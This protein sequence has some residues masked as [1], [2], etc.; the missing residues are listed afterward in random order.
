MMLRHQL[1]TVGVGLSLA[2]GYIF[3]HCP[4]Q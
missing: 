4:N 3:E 1:T 2:N